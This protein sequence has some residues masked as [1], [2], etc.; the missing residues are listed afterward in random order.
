M[1]PNTLKHRHRVVLGAS[2]LLLA[3]LALVLLFEREARTPPS[4][5]AQPRAALEPT[6]VPAQPQ[7]QKEIALVER[8]APIT[9]SVFGFVRGTTG[10]GISSAAVCVFSSVAPSA[11][12]RHCTV[13]DP[14]GRFRLDDIRAGEIALSASAQGFV[15]ESRTLPAGSS[16]GPLTLTL[17]AGG[18]M[19]AG[20]I[21]DALGGPI[22]GALVV[23][24]DTQ[25]R[26]ITALQTGARGEFHIDVE[27][28]P[29]LLEASAE[30][31]SRGALSVRAPADAVAIALTPASEL[32]GRVEANGV[33]VEGARVV[34]APAD[35]S[36]NGASET[37]SDASGAFK[38]AELPAGS[39]Q[40]T[41][42]RSDQLSKPVW[43]QLVVGQPG[44]TTLL[45][46]EQAASLAATVRVGREP[47][48]EGRLSLNGQTS[49]SEP[50]ESG[51]ARVDGVTP[52]T[53]DVEVSCSTGAP[54]R[55]SI[56][57]RTGVTTREFQVDSGRALRGRVEDSRGRGVAGAW[58]SLEPARPEI[59][60]GG[61]NT[62]DNGDFAC[63]GLAPAEY[64]CSARTGFGAVGEKTHVDLKESDGRVTLRLAASA[65][66]RVTLTGNDAQHSARVFAQQRQ[67][68]IVPAA[69]HGDEL[70]F[71]RL[72]LGEYKVFMGSEGASDE[73]GAV[74]A[75]K[76]D[77][78]VARVR[79]A[80]P[81]LA[82]IRGVVIDPAGNPVLDTWVRAVS[83][84][85]LL[86]V[87]ADTPSAA[88]TDNQGH[89][90]LSGLI[91][92]RYDV[93]TRCD[94]EDQRVTGVQAGATDVVLRLSA[95]IPQQA[96]E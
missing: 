24:R 67:G 18:A 42:T 81:K 82:S 72:P 26:I 66:I 95:V 7:D 16:E 12:F 96:R 94:T 89:F 71:E 8:T 62:D 28:G 64:D 59:P 52:G 80:S 70:V 39:Y 49:R 74:V 56:E 61:C 88:I 87:Y 14:S 45:Q 6:V 55:E 11:S 1:L 25:N 33:P 53:Y 9:R 21:S 47:C 3:A 34:A 85:A 48:L 19:L 5:G 63:R 35:G 92:G 38:L 44:G 43:V 73:S 30:T 23:A 91:P 86:G 51:A 32:F 78:E 41:A 36:M 83:S 79:L 27:P 77:G 58:V 15:A 29:L 60:G 76:Q 20:T 2:T 93:C 40:L 84:N 37:S 31:Y 90:Q 65:S 75:L 57:L 17:R 68:A 4:G 10:A 13:S 22:A 46:L 69:A 54:H 50:I